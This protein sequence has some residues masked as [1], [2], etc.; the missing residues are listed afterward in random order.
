MSPKTPSSTRA[1]ATSAL[2]EIFALEPLRVIVIGNFE[3]GS[4]F[5][6]ALIPTFML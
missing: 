5:W 1:I 6:G 2:L 3:A 4:I